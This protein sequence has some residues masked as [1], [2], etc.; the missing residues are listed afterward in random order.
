MKY[1]AKVYEGLIDQKHYEQMGPSIWLYMYLLVKE[2]YGP[3]ERRPVISDADLARAIGCGKRVI[4]DWRERLIGHRY[5]EAT[6]HS[7]GYSYTIT[8]SKKFTFD[9]SNGGQETVNQRDVSGRHKN[10]NHET[11]V[12]RSFPSHGTQFFVAKSAQTLS[13]EPVS[14]PNKV[15]K[16]KSNGNSPAAEGAEG[17]FSSTDSDQKQKHIALSGSPLAPLKDAVLGVMSDVFSKP[18]GKGSSPR[19]ICA[20]ELKRQMRSRRNRGWRQ[21]L[22]P[23]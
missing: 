7:R 3:V 13:G 18:D 14:S 2:T 9:E 1:Y 12:V 15:I 16:G 21:S 5:I 23:S 4:R 8:K 20:A 11:S 6:L 22:L 10:V 19:S 17:E